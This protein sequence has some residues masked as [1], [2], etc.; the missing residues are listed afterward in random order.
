MADFGSTNIFG[1]LTVSRES[2]FKNNA[3][4]NKDVSISGNVSING[5]TLTLG[6]TTSSTDK[7]LKILAGDTAKA[8]IEL[9]GNV[10]GTGY[11]Y[12]GQDSNN[13][14]GII[15]NGDDNPDLPFGVDMVS[16]F[17]RA[18]GVD[19]EV[20]GYS[21]GS[22]TVVFQGTSRFINGDATY[23]T[24]T[25][26][27]IEVGA[28]DTTRAGAIK[29]WGN[30]AGA[31][32]LIQA[33]TNNLYIDSPNVLALNHFSGN[34]V[35]IGPDGSWAQVNST[36]LVFTEGAGKGVKFWGSEFYK[37]YMSPSTDA[38]WGGRLDSTSDYNM[39]FRMSS[40]TNRGFVFLNDRT[41]VAQI[42]ATGKIYANALSIGG[43]DTKGSGIVS[44]TPTSTSWVHT[45]ANGTKITASS[46]APTGGADGDIWFQ[47]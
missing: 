25:L 1:R 21:V 41:P 16:F 40:G 44:F 4:F 24:G 39:Y 10:Q 26:A 46:S 17:T 37:I 45:F 42:D 32:G 11:L 34:G 30:T 43:I 12:V 47:V 20:F 33:T 14:G 5:D 7:I 2:F 27:S 3:I 13:G 35:I 9:Y 23:G 29:I 6:S 31:Y 8:G 18:G 36:G 22:T 15:Y 38:S 28:N 19:R